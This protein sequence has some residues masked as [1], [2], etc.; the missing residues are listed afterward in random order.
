MALVGD[1]LE[2]APTVGNFLVLGERVGDVREGAEIRAKDLGERFR[3][4]FALGFLRLHQEIER[5]LERQFLTADLE[6]QRGDRLVEHPVPGRVARHRFFVEQLLDAV[7][8]LIRLLLADVLDP[9]P[10]VAES[11]VR[12]RLLDQPVI[13]AIEF[14]REEQEMRGS[15]GDF[16]LH[17]AVE[18][19]ALRIGRIA[20]IDETRERAQPAEQLPDRLETLDRG[21]EFFARRRRCGDVGELSLV[22]FL[23]SD[24]FGVGAR[25][26][27]RHLR[28]VDR[29]I[30]IGEIPLGQS[31]ARLVHAGGSGRKVKDGR[32]GFGHGRD[33]GSEEI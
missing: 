16:F 20:G 27:R 32:Y 22:G 28:C 15:G 24:A 4:L 11:G 33:I 17:V 1:V 31:G 2:A 26:I 5:G 30:K 8:Q 3:R 21:A 7:F 12:K 9:R 18:L 6:A 23:E 10:V 13:D 14:E 25:E 29:G 19:G